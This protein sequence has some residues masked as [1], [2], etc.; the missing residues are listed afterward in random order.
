[1]RC[2]DVGS[3]SVPGNGEYD[4]KEKVMNRE[5]EVRNESIREGWSLESL[6]DRIEMEGL[7]PGDSECTSKC[8]I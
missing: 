2:A 3:D 1:M 5:E 6:E 7:I 8:S 4:R